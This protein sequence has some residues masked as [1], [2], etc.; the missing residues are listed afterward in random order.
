MSNNSNAA[1]HGDG[2]ASGDERV[3]QLATLV[4]V[5][6]DSPSPA[7][8]ASASETLMLHRNKRPGDYHYGKW[9]GLGGKFLP[10]E[11]AEECAEREVFEES[12]LTISSLDWRGVITF[13][14]FDGRRDW[15]V[16]VFTASAH[17]GPLCEPPEGTLSWIPTANLCELTVWPGDRIFLPWIWGEMRFSAR[18]V[19][20]GGELSSHSVRWYAR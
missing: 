20:T 1:A 13:P 2:A 5:Q 14:L 19:Y 7:L 11:T 6:R 8:S 9:N 12:G 3:T 18:F 4:Y 16:F 17:D 10:G 15:C